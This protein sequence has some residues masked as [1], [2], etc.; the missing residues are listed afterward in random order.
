MH[1]SVRITS[2]VNGNFSD[3][4]GTL[5]GDNRVGLFVIVRSDSSGENGKDEFVST[6]HT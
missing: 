1:G 2:D 4:T 6:I 3:S 5:S